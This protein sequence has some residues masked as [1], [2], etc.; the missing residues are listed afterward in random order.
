MLARAA[1]FRIAFD[2]SCAHQRRREER[3]TA[4]ER[5]R[6]DQKRRGARIIRIERRRLGEPGPEDFLDLGGRQTGERVDAHFLDE[7]GYAGVV[8]VDPLSRLLFGFARR[9]APMSGHAATPVRSS[10]RAYTSRTGRRG[11]AGLFPPDFARGE[12]RGAGEMRRSRAR[13]AGACEDA[14]GMAPTPIDEPL[15]DTAIARR[16][17]V[18]WA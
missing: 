13:A 11:I 3:E 18:A 10:F 9:R 15:V 8:A 17:A 6:L 5:Q 12:Q 4:G 1:L 7:R 16:C 2:R 14:T